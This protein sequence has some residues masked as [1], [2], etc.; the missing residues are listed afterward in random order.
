MNVVASLQNHFRVAVEVDAAAI[1]VKAAVLVGTQED[2]ASAR[3][4]LERAER[5]AK[6][7]ERD[8]SSDL[9]F[10]QPILWINTFGANSGEPI[11]ILEGW[12]VAEGVPLDI[13]LSDGRKL[14]QR[15]YLAMIEAPWGG[16]TEHWVREEDVIAVPSHQP[17]PD[18]RAEQNSGANIAELIETAI[19]DI[20]SSPG[21]DDIDMPPPQ[22]GPGSDYGLDL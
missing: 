2:I 4:R 8:N 12:I 6:A 17:S 18:T 9:N 14:L 1:E 3:V 15:H 22:T 19:A 5:A 20:D 7:C 13:P 10:G 16:E 11:G 21:V